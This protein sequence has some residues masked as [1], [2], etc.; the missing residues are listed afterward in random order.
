M[1]YEYHGYLIPFLFFILISIEV[2][3]AQPKAGN[4]GI[5]A[6]VQEQQL[7][8]YF[9]VWVGNRIVLAPALGYLNAS[10]KFTDIS[11]G[12]SFR[13]YVKKE[14]LSSYLGL[15][16]G[17]FIYTPKREDTVFD[18]LVGLC[19]GSEYY[20][21][22]RFCIG[23]ELQLNATISNEASFRFGNPGGTNFNT[24]TA[25]FFTFYFK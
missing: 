14:K 16:T 7:D 13:G 25:L 9:P 3:S 10:H 1:K 19:F 21:D 2:L 18:Y 17:T 23:G 4:I 6:A 8:F 22:S 20:L 12:F 5:S 24:A 11:L 15:R